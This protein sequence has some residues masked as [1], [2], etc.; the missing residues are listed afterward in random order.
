MSLS[1]HNAIT[2]WTGGRMSG[3]SGYYAGRGPLSSDLNSDLLEQ[4]YQGVKKDIGEA[5]A[6]ALVVG[7][8]SE[9]FNGWTL[10]ALHRPRGPAHRPRA[11]VARR[12]LAGGAGVFSSTHRWI[13]G[14]LHARLS[15]L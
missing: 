6:K 14:R 10:L 3:R 2:V 8:E 15:V 1:V 7:V 9:L 4:I 12:G 13:Y 5:Q 11:R